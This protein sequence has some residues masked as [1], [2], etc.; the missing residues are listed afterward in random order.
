ML[1]QF[2]YNTFLTNRKFTGFVKSFFVKWA[3]FLAE[4]RFLLSFFSKK[5]IPGFL[6]V[7]TEPT[8]LSFVQAIMP[9]SIS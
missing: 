9:L 5:C 3:V 6:P 2:V 7:E 1:M 4:N 8:L